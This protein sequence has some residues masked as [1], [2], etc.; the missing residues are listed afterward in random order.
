M[1]RLLRRTAKTDGDGRDKR[2]DA[3]QDK[4]KPAEGEFPDVD[5]CLVIIGSCWR[6]PMS[7]GDDARGRQV[8]SGSILRTTIKSTSARNTAV[9]FY[10]GV[11]RGVIYIS[12]GKAMSRRVYRL[13]RE[14]YLEWDIL[15]E[16]V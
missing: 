12:A 16:R 8:W 10:P 1:K 9:A 6:L 13:V 11:Y 5:Q 2:P 3:D 4:G 15:F 14:L 7:P